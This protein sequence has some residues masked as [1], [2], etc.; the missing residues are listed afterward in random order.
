MG[1]ISRRVG[2]SNNYFVPI[3]ASGGTI[4]TIESA[5]GVFWRVHTF[6]NNGTFTV[7][8]TGTTTGIDSGGYIEFLI[9]AGGGSG[10]PGLASGITSQQTRAGGGGG[11]GVIS[12]STTVSTTNYN[13]VVGAGGIGPA[14]GAT[15]SGNDGG[16]SSAFSFTAIGGGG[17]GG[18]VSGLL[19]GRPGGSGGG[20]GVRP[21]SGI[22]GAGGGGTVGQ[23]NSGAGASGVTGFGGGGGGAGGGTGG[24]VGGL[25]LPSSITGSAVQYSP[26]GS[27]R[28]SQGSGAAATLYG[29]GGG[30]G[31]GSGGG[32][33]GFQG[34]VIVRYPLQRTTSVA[35]NDNYFAF[36]SLLLHMNGTTG[37][38]AFLDSSNNNFSM[39]GAGNVQISNAVKQFGTGSAYF[40]G[41]GDYIEAPLN[42]A[43]EFGTGDFTIEFW[44]YPTATSFS[45]YVARWSSGTNN[46]FFIGGDTSSGIAVYINDAS[47]AKIT[48]GTIQVNQWQHIALV[49]QGTS[50]KAYIN[51]T[52][53]GSTYTI[54]TA[55]INSS[56]NNL[57]IGYDHYGN[58]FF[59]GYIDELRITKG[60]ARYTSNFAPPT[61]QFP[62]N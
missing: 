28:T 7:T 53:A 11:G 54:G 43:F 21:S 48:G 3:E 9:V 35:I 38:T 59:Q 1:F 62:D 42:S 41:T 33:N 23:G 29:G 20:G 13:V 32:G 57:R 56:T 26:G 6:T 49:R 12:G 15:A 34:I 47:P 22:V 27:A 36:V 19:T 25:G 5:P 39:T 31:W 18:Y 46:A 52:Q 50:I 61:A 24:T 4:S 2:L 16:S 44:V 17:G 8:R 55:A 51:G 45:T 14:A 30:G 10:G 60:I 37:S 40:D 58:P